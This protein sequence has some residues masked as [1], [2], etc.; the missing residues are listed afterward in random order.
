MTLDGGVRGGRPVALKTAVDD[1]LRL[2]VADGRPTPH[3]VFVQRRAGPGV[4]EH[5]AGWG[6]GAQ[7]GSRVWVCVHVHACVFLCGSGAPCA[8]PLDCAPSAP[9]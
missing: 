3:T 9:R 8:L 5:A 4:G 1:A 6:R 7:A 2:L